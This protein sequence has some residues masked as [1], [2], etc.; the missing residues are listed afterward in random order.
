MN[1]N[2][3]FGGDPQI[4]TSTTIHNDYYQSIE[5]YIKKNQSS[6]QCEYSP[7]STLTNIKRIIAIGDIHGDFNS[8]LSALYHGKVIDRNGNWT[9]DP[10]Y[11]KTVVIQVGDLLDKG[12]RKIELNTNLNPDDDEW[13]I[14]IFMQYLNNQALQSGGGVYL[15][16]GNHELMNIKGDLR[17]TSQNTNIIFGGLQNRKTL[18][19]RGS[20]LAKKLAC[21]TNSVMKINDWVFVHAGITPENVKGYNSIEELNN[22]VR[23]YLLKKKEV[24]VGTPLDNLLNNPNSIFWTRYY[25]SIDKHDVCKTLEK[26]LNMDILQSSSQKKSNK[27]GMIVG[28]TPKHNIQG[29][30]DQQFYF[31]DTMMSSAFKEKN[32]TSDRVQVLEIVDNHKITILPK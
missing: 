4:P 8:L 32:T 31:V 10:K 18:F 13:K 30:C 24:V 5:S 26:T 16:L 20:V 23:L 19:M 7:P 28:H 22:D 9:T 27:G 25:N 3:Y 29:M 21:M 1:F 2:Y 12:G 14:L 17:Y 6:L 11:K 15:L